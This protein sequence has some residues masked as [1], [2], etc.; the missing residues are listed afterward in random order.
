MAMLDLAFWWVGLVVCAVGT[1]AAIVLAVSALINFLWRKY[2]EAESLFS[3]GSK[4]P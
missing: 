1:I 2:A 4:T 3:H